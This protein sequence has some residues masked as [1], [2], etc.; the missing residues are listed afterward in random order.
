MIRAFVALA[1]SVLTFHTTLLNA[2]ETVEI[3][4]EKIQNAVK[5]TYRKADD[6]VCEMFNGKLKCVAKKVKHSV[7]NAADSISTDAK[8]LKNK[9]DPTK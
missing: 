3:K 6:K 5:K 9:V 1:A 4:A 2:E 7:E 8:D